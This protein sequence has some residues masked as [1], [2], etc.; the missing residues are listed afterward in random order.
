MRFSY[1]ALYAGKRT[2][3][4]GRLIWEGKEKQSCNLVKW[5]RENGGYRAPHLPY[6]W[7]LDQGTL[8]T[9]RLRTRPSQL[10]RVQKHTRQMCNALHHVITCYLSRHPGVARLSLEETPRRELAVLSNLQNVQLRWNWRHFFRDTNASQLHRVFQYYLYN[11]DFFPCFQ[12]LDADIMKRKLSFIAPFH[13]RLKIFSALQTLR[14]AR[15]T[16]E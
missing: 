11:L 8:Y 1:H 16:E 4:K 6:H 13:A 2:I 3:L 12:Y 14:T 9:L 5:D 15:T 7:S 10:V